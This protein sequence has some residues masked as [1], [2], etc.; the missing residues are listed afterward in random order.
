MFCAARNAYFVARRA[1]NTVIPSHHNWFGT[2]YIDRRNTGYNLRTGHE[3]FP[4]RNLE[5]YHEKYWEQDH[6]KNKSESFNV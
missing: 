3:V 1:A 5:Y 2:F 6:L 4:L